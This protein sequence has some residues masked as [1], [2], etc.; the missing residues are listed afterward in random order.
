MTYARA[1]FVCEHIAPQK[2][3]G[4]DELLVIGEAVQKILDME[5]IN[6]VSKGTLLKIVRL[7]FPMCFDVEG[8]EDDAT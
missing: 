4:E 2:Q 7:L 1:I 6:A 8:A 5:T 3:Y